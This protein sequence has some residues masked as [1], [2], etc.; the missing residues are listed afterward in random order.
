MKTIQDIL[1]WLI[2]AENNGIDTVGTQNVQRHLESLRKNQLSAHGVGQQPK[3][4]EALNGII[5]CCDGNEPS[6][7]QIYYIAKDAVEAIGC[8][9]HKNQQETEKL[10]GQLAEMK[11]KYNAL[12]PKCTEEAREL[13]H[14][15]QMTIKTINS[16]QC[17]SPLETFKKDEIVLF[18]KETK[19]RVIIPKSSMLIEEEESGCIMWV[20]TKRLAKQE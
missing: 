4:L 8:N 12:K 7:K 10:K 17:C 9:N 20:E 14:N 2:D 15:I 19:V 18:D 6:H 1:D 11:L 5:K 16:I 13:L 3:L